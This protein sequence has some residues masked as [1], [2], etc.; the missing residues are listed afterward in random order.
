MMQNR[1][2]LRTKW[3][4]AL[5]RAARA[6]CLLTAAALLAVSACR[7]APAPPQ[8]SSSPATAGP[9]TAG[10]LHV[11]VSILPQ[12][13]FV[14]RIGGPRMHVDV[15]VGPGQN[16]H[17]FEPT[18]GQMAALAQARVLFG[19]GLPFEDAL[20]P[21]VRASFQR[22]EIVDTRQGV[23]LRRIEAHEVESDAHEHQAHDEH[24]QDHQA[25]GEDP[26]IWLAPKLVK[27]QAQTIADTLAQIDPEHADE[28]RR[29]L[30]A[31][32]ADLDA[33]DVRLAAA[34]APLKGKAFF[35][36]HPAF[37]YFADAYGLKQVPVEIEGKEPAPKDVAAL[38]QQARQAG[39]KVVF[40]QPQFPTRAAE[41]VAQ[42]IGGAVVPLDDLPRDYLHSMEALAEQV[43]KALQGG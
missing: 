15:L 40:V 18:P 25:G 5:P 31:F 22:L 24:D 28:F 36:F 14:E 26:H 4:Q 6:A 12:A 35:V 37:G 21:K 27:I 16:P 10:Q 29:N 11:F 38:I 13:Y 39:V 1:H 20:L 3:A 17:S 34:L 30:A 2:K 43:R 41:M 33:L 8:T 19:I 32:D 42:Q 23:P 9:P 7:R